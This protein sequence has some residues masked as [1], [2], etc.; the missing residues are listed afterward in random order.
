MG[1]FRSLFLAAGLSLVLAPAAALADSDVADLFAA[2]DDCGATDN[3]RLSFDLGGYSDACGNLANAPGGFTSTSETFTSATLKP[4]WSLDPT[5]KGKISVG[6][7][8]RESAGYGLGGQTIS[9]TL[10]AKKGTSTV[11]LYSGSATKDAAAMLGGAN[12]VQ[13]FEFSLNGKVGPYKSYTLDV[14]VSGAALAGY[15]ST[16]GDTLVEL[17][18]PDGTVLVEPEEEEE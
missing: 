3:P 15:L 18:V 1:T 17:P 10:T 11:T 2:R 6:V 13:D 7:S 4:L 16:G 14:D 5:R 8:S 9:V 12:Y